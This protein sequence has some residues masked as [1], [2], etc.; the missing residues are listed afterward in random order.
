MLAGG[1]G[2]QPLFHRDPSAPPPPSPARP[3]QCTYAA[4]R[5]GRLGA[6]YSHLLAPIFHAHIRALAAG[7]SADAVARVTAALASWQWA[8]RPA[9]DELPAAAAAAPK[10]DAAAA[11]LAAWQY[12]QP[13][14]SLLAHTPLAELANA[15]L[16]SYNSLRPCLPVDAGAWVVGDCVLVLQV[17]PLPPPH[18]HTHLAAPLPIGPRARPLTPP[19]RPLHSR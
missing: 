17:G 3:Q 14:P 1:E 8:H 13:P 12:L 7:R 2:R 11:D 10:G 4:R 16:A 5:A 19:R 18:T 15:A 9:Y 6:D